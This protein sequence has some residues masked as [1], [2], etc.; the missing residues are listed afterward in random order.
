VG[1]VVF[2]GETMADPVVTAATGA[3]EQHY[4]QHDPEIC[5]ACKLK[6]IQFGS[7]QPATHN[8]KSDKRWETDPVKERIEEIHGIKIDTDLMNRRRVDLN[9]NKE[10]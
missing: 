1:F 8:P 4:G 10:I 3:R 7:M 6:T 5:F 2:E 9:N